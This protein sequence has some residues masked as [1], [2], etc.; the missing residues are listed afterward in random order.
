MTKL[1]VFGL[2]KLGCPMLAVFADSGYNVVGCD[3]NESFVN[4]VNQGIVPVDEP[5]VQELL[6]NNQGNFSATSD[7][8]LAVDQTQA[9]FIIVPTPSGEDGFFINDYVVDAVAQIGTA[10][11]HKTEYHLVVVTSTVMPGSTEGIIKRALEDASGR[12]VGPQLG[13]CYSPEFIA[14]GTVVRDMQHPDIVLVGQSDEKAGDLLESV[15]LKVV[16][17]NP[18]CHRMNFVCAELAKISINTFVTT[19]ISYANM[20]AELCD[21]LPGADVEMVTTA[22]GGDTRIGKKYL[23]GAIGYGG[24]CFPRDNK[25]FSSLGRR[26][27]VSVDLAE[28]TDLI[29]DH[30]VQR[31]VRLVRSHVRPGS[32]IAILGLSYK[33]DTSVSTESQSFGLAAALLQDYKI[34]LSDPCCS[35]CQDLEDLTS[36]GVSFQRDY[37]HVVPDADAII[38][39]TPWRDYQGLSSTLAEHDKLSVTVIDPWRVVAGASIIKNLLLPGK[40]CMV[41]ALGTP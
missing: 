23:K 27:E 9:S 31:F 20:L 8:K 16:K 2:G 36:M 38:I 5:G 11:R 7:V 17:S 22:I 10:L 37:V 15:M 19:K 30:Q 33:P 21:A 18:E 26:L 34:L 41:D 28:A 1:S 35:W 6:E 32:C 4:S 29:N 39:M 12:K 3:V 25:A 14:L 40:H 13:L 24:P